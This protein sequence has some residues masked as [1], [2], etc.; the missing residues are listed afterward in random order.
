MGLQDILPT[1][2]TLT[3]CPLAKASDGADLTPVLKDRSAKVREGTGHV[4]DIYYS[5]YGQKNWQTAMVTDGRW[6][7]CYAEQGPTEELYDLQNDPREMVNLAS[8]PGNKKLLSEWKQKLMAEAR[9]YNHTNIFNGDGQLLATPCDR[10][11]LDKTP[12]SEMGW[13]WY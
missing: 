5:N 2:A 3:G 11:A 8:R 6:K 4:R 13:R 7:Y 10:A 1:L 12:V 9:R